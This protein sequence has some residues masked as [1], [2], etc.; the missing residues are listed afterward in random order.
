MEIFLQP[1]G[2]GRIH[3]FQGL[4]NEAVDSDGSARPAWMHA[5][6]P[7]MPTLRK[8]FCKAVVQRHCIQPADVEEESLDVESFGSI[9][10]NMHGRSVDAAVSHVVRECEP[11]TFTG[12]G[13]VPVQQFAVP[14][15]GIRRKWG[16][17]MKI[18]VAMPL[19]RTLPVA[20]RL[21]RT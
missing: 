13:R 17:L 2:F 11:T 5:E 12:L 14:I 6:V 21:R 8:P 7:D 1:R 16:M 15:H 19:S 10:V 3:A 4:V 9:H 20:P 18:G